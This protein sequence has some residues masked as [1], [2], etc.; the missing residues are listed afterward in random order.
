[1]LIGQFK[2]VE[3]LLGHTGDL[4]GRVKDNL[5]KN[6]DNA[7]LSKRLVTI[8]CETPCDVDLDSLK[9]QP[10]DDAK[11]KALLVEFEFNSIGKRLYAK[12]YKAGRGSAAPPSEAK[13]K[14]AA[15]NVKPADDLV[16]IPDESP[17]TAET[18]PPA[19]AQLKT[20]SEVVHEY[21]TV[22]SP[23]ERAA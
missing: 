17:A 13:K 15:R 20:I 3:N 1:K 12:D 4:T 23:S 6:R 10:A 5:E 16:L 7:L 18:K 19:S 11:V 21:H 14:T 2:S 9:L 8:D 22:S